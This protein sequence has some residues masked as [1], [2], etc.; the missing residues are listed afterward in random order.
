[1]HRA[2]RYNDASRGWR[3]SARRSRRTGASHIRGTGASWGAPLTA[4]LPARPGGGPALPAQILAVRHGESELNLA[5]AQG[6]LTELV[7][8]GGRDAD[9]ALSPL[10]EVQSA[11]LG[12]WLARLPDHRL[13]EAVVCSPFVRARETAR[14]VRTELNV[15]GRPV[16]ELTVDERLRDREGGILDIFHGRPVP[17]DE[18]DRRH[19]LGELYYRPPGGESLA[20]VALRV[21]TLLTDLG[22]T[23][24]DRR[25][26]LVA[27]DAVVLMLHYALDGLSE[28]DLNHLIDSNPVRNASVSRWVRTDGRLR[29]ARYNGTDHLGGDA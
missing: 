29:L 20:D 18:L 14:I 13:P 23:H 21:R 22:W 3:R 9:A 19:K 5:D 25:V 1:M 8:R 16:P 27:H 10:G 11:R 12:Q 7:A 24:A 4:G 17:A 6:R 15:A 26:L 2:A 28:A